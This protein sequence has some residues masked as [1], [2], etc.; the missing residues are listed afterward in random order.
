M[1]S[2]FSPESIAVVGVSESRTR[3]AYI[4]H[5]EGLP[6]SQIAGFGF[7]RDANGGVVLDENGLPQQGEFQ[8]FGTG[9][10]PT[11]MGLSNT[12]SYKNL[13][14][15]F[16]IDM[17]TGGKIYAATNAYA[18]A[19]GLH[20]NTLLGRE[21]G[22]LLYGSTIDSDQVDDYYNRIG[23]NITEEFVEDASFAKLRQLVL[24][25]LN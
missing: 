17:Q 12:F 1:K 2:L 7:V 10:H 6:Y 5:V 8:H 24:T 4:Q 20:K 22:A 21:G 15:S 3:N 14:L 19:R 25:S 18:Y 16:L 11:T 23:F 9:V 13:S